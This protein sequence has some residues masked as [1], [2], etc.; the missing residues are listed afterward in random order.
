MCDYQT[1]FHDDQTGYIVRCNSCEKIQLAYGNLV[2]TFS[3][4][5]FPRFH[6]RISRMHAQQDR[7]INKASRCIMIATPCQAMKLLVSLQELDEFVVML[8]T[9]LVELQSLALLKLFN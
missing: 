1:L 7:S 5:E 9:A 2:I 8:E 3:E 6:S 4:E